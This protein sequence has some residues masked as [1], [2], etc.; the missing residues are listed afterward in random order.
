MLYL[1]VVMVLVF[2]YYTTWFCQQVYPVEL[3]VCVRAER[4]KILTV[5]L[6]RTTRSFYCPPMYLYLH[7]YF[8]N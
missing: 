5:F 2:Y 1:L 6:V 3:V 8:L 4:S 7:F